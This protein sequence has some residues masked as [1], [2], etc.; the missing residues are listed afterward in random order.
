MRH[1]QRPLLPETSMISRCR[2]VKHPLHSRFGIPF[3]RSYG[4]SHFGV[5]APPAIARPWLDCL[6]SPCMNEPIPNPPSTLIPK[7]CMVV[8]ASFYHV[9]RCVYTAAPNHPQLLCDI[10]RGLAQTCRSC[11]TTCTN[12]YQKLPTGNENQPPFHT[13]HHTVAE[14]I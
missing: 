13:P 6:L 10:S 4:S 8:V 14:Q 7:H 2:Q 12:R 5:A 11:K 9:L 1:S 3:R